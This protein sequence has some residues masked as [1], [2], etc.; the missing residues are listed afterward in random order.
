M[1]S[2]AA[3]VVPYVSAAMGVYGAAVVAR[4]QEAAA[5]ATVGVGGRL[6]RRLLGR[7]E[8]A[9]AME[10]AAAELA[11][12]PGDQDRV[13]GLRLQIR[14]ALEADPQLMADLVEILSEA[15]ATVTAAGER[16]VAVRDNRG[17]VQTGDGSTAWQGP[18]RR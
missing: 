14:K 13:A 16:S 12:D 17:I 15:G 8:S 18:G 5:D 7:A 2:V 3:A 6:L 11:Q 4:V 1:T 10:A 9:P